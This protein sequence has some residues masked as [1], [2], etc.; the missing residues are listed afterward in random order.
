MAKTLSSM[1]G[2]P[3][4]I[5]G[6]GTRSLMPQVGPHATTKEVQCAVKKTQHSENKKKSQQEEESNN[7]NKKPNQDLAHNYFE[8]QRGKGTRWTR[9]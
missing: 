5:P 9:G 1:Q 2:A 3:G 7:S 4:S 6:Q 8:G